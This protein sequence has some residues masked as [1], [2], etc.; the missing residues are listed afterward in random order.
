MK[1]YVLQIIATYT[2]ITILSDCKAIGLRSFDRKIKLSMHV[3]GVLAKAEGHKTKGDEEFSKLEYNSAIDFYT[4][5]LEVKCKDEEFNAN[6]YS[7]RAT[8][9]YLLGMYLKRK[10][11]FLTRILLF[12]RRRLNIRIFLPIL[13]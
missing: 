13:G 5:G 4:K 3:F 11:Q 8:S 9:H 1:V 2:F 7:A 10:L 12:F 6:L